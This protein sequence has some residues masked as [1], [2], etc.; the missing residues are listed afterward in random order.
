MRWPNL[1]VK[2]FVSDSWGCKYFGGNEFGDLAK[3]IVYG[4]APHYGQSV[5]LVHTECSWDEAECVSCGHRVPVYVI[6]GMCV[7]G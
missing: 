6:F 5:C 7:C 3:N 1:K 4:Y 2:G